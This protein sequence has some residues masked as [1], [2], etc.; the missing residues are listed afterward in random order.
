[1]LLDDPDRRESLAHG[2]SGAVLGRV[3]EDDGLHGRAAERL[4]TGEQQLAR[5]GVDERDRD[6]GHY[7][8]CVRPAAQEGGRFR[9]TST[10]S[11]RTGSRTPVSRAQSAIRRRPSSSETVSSRPNTRCSFAWSE[12]ACTTSSRAGRNSISG[13]PTSKARATAWARSST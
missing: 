10:L 6:V 9:S 11:K 1:R 13:S 12:N 7:T 2:R 5:V 4:E 3:V 8:V